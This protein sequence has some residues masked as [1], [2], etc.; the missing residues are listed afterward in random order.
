MRYKPP[1]FPYKE[2]LNE[3]S[4]LF[5]SD[6]KKNKFKDAIVQGESGDLALTIKVENSDYYLSSDVREERSDEFALF[7][8]SLEENYGIYYSLMRYETECFYKNNIENMEGSAKL[9]EEERMKEYENSLL[10]QNDCYITIVYCCITKDIG[11]L[12]TSLSSFLETV[13]SLIDTLKNINANPIVVRGNLLISFLKNLIVPSVNE[14][15]LPY[16][17]CPLYKEID[18]YDIDIDSVPLK[19]KEYNKTYYVRTISFTSLPSNTFPDML[20]VLY[21]FPFTIRTCFKFISLGEKKGEDEIVQQKNRY[22]SSIFSLKEHVKADM[23]GKDVSISDEMKHSAIYGKEEC[24]SALIRLST[25]KEKAGYF[26]G[27]IVVYSFSEEE[28][29]NITNQIRSFLS[30]IGFLTK[31]ETIA[32]SLLFYT[33]LPLYNTSFRSLLMLSSNVADMLTFSSPYHGAKNS[34]LLKKRTGSDVPLLILKN[35]DS[36]PYYFSLSGTNGE[37]GH[38]LI[39]GPT[40]CGKSVFI[41]MLA[42]SYLKYDNTRV[43]IIDRDLSSLNIVKNNGGDI[44]Y[45]FVN[46][47]QF[48]PLTFDNSFLRNNLAFLKAIAESSGLLWSADIESDVIS[49]L[50]LLDSHISEL[51]GGTLSTFYSVLKGCYPKCELLKALAKYIAP[52]GN[53]FDGSEDLLTFSKRIT[54]IETNKFLDS[55]NANNKDTLPLMIHILS[56]LDKALTDS[57]PTLFIMDESWKLLKNAVFKEFFE[58]WIK[59]LRKKNTDIVFSVTN[60]SDI[61]DKDIA[62]TILSNIETRVFMSDKS[63]RESIQRERYMSMGLNETDINIIA[64]SGK[65]HALIM[66]DGT[67]AYVNA[68]FSPILKYLYTSDDMKRELLC[69]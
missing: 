66:N 48:K 24:E 57:K 7:L 40:G 63:A 1:H 21:S 15:L 51:V 5:L 37:K 9:I 68:D 52:E 8:S 60:L 38:T 29:E 42:A 39:T 65:Y 36:S 2:I 12:E 54:L 31:I 67:K 3:N 56:S 53:I 25:K 43:V 32:N 46:T 10:L 26:T 20:N 69:D 33:S 50:S 41:S 6:D 11:I 61:T 45:P 27:I 49:I 55:G 18:T 4:L 35:Y 17:S 64:A 34:A 16:S 30:K 19:I 59:T 22:K 62:E 23:S 28:S 58:E 47:Y 14:C 13:E 44:I